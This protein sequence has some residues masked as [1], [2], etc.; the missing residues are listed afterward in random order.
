MGDFVITRKVK[1]VKEPD[2]KRKCFIII[3]VNNG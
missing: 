3:K 2:L 1:N